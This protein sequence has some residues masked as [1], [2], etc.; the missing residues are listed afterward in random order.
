MGFGVGQGAR[1]YADGIDA[2]YYIAQR[3]F[4]IE[5]S[6]TNYPIRLHRYGIHRDSGGPGR[7]RGGCGIVREIEL[8]GSDATLMLRLTN[9]VHPP[10]GMNGG[11]SGRA[12]R[13]T[14]NPGT[15]DERRLPMLA[16]GVEMRRGE[17]L[18]IETPGGG[19]VGHPF[20]RPVER[21]LRDVLGEFISVESALQDYGVVIDVENERV[22]VEA[23][24]EIRNTRR[25]ATSLV[26]RHEYFDEDAWYA[27]SHKLKEIVAHA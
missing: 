25:W 9:C 21:V 13:F 24:E 23:T 17:I 22:D 19:G 7:W 12:G 20:D 27:A 10:F 5:F 6:E 15:P 16:E 2:V 4:P 11:M 14:M 26:H 1:P 18:R 3:N 8:L